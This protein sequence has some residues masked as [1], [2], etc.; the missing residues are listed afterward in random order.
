MLDKIYVLDAD[1][2][3]MESNLQ[4][5]YLKNSKVIFVD[6]VL[7]VEKVNLVVP[8]VRDSFPVNS[9]SSIEISGD[10]ILTLNVIILTKELHV[11]SGDDDS[12]A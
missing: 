4:R 10:F 11:T 2:K 1:Y 6:N 9:Q 3:Q 12:I 7:K 5:H 8:K